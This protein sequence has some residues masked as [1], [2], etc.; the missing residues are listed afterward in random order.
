TD[1]ADID[2]EPEGRSCLVADISK[3]F[4]TLIIFDTGFGED[5][6]LLI[7]LLIFEKDV[8]QRTVERM[9]KRKL[10]PICMM[11]LVMEIIVQTEQIQHL[12]AAAQFRLALAQ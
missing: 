12:I 10:A 7:S 3:P 9:A 8:A 1:A 5:K 4:G 11:P 2:A 6:R